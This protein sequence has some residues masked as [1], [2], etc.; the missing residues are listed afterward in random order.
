MIRNVAGFLC[1]RWTI[2]LCFA[3]CYIGTGVWTLH[4]QLD[5][6]LTTAVSMRPL[7]QY[8][9]VSGVQS[10]NDYTRRLLLL[11]L[12][13]PRWPPCSHHLPHSTQRIVYWRVEVCARSATRRNHQIMYFAVRPGWTRRGCSTRRRG[14][15]VGHQ[16]TLERYVM[17]AWRPT[18][19]FTYL[20]RVNPMEP[21]APAAI[22]VDFL[23]TN[24]FKSYS[25]IAL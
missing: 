22:T 16:T 11:L 7:M 4:A 19:A 5:T 2:L 1:Y 8:G 6:D 20:V 17:A 25:L 18:I 9:L 13:L 24:R 3:W 10:Y 23:A 12:L 14:V 21:P 15:A